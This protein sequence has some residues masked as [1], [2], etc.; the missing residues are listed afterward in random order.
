MWLSSPGMRAENS[1]APVGAA[2]PRAIVA[3]VSAWSRAELV[4]SRGLDLV[5]AVSLA[6][7]ALPVL[8]VTACW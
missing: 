4:A 6:I 1:L 5:V 2:D 8:L 7:V 3:D